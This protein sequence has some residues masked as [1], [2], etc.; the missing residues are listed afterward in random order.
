MRL[1]FWASLGSGYVTTVVIG[2]TSCLR[3]VL[4]IF[5]RLSF[6]VFPFAFFW[7]QGAV[8]GAVVITAAALSLLVPFFFPPPVSVSFEPFSCASSCIRVASFH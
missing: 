3:R 5:V 8:M 7:R 6:Y 1:A 2:T 4:A